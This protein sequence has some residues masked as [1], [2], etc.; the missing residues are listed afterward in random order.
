[1][2]IVELTLKLFNVCTSPAA[3]Y[4]EAPHNGYKYGSNGP[5]NYYNNGPY[6]PPPS[7]WQ[8]PH[9]PPVQGI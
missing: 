2:V 7:N 3:Q 1:M 6:R 4:G 9:Q 5:D 8:S